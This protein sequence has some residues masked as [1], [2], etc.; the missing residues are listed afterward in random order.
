MHLLARCATILSDAEA[1][2][3]A[4]WDR[5]HDI[6]PAV[7]RVVR[8]QSATASCKPFSQIWRCH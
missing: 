1:F 4:C 3:E 6:P 8:Y 7:R 5:P 2:E